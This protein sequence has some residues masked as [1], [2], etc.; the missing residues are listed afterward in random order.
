LTKILEK[1]KKKTT[2]KGKVLEEKKGKG[3]ASRI[4]RRKSM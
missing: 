1:N 3:W 4:F 2:E